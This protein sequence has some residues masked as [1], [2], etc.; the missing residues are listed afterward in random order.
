MWT[1]IPIHIF[2]IWPLRRY[3]CGV[4][5]AKLSLLPRF[6]PIPITT[7]SLPMN[8]NASATEMSFFSSLSFSWCHS[9]ADLKCIKTM[10]TKKNEVIIS[11]FERFS[12]F[13]LRFFLNT[14]YYKCITMYCV[15]SIYTH[16]YVRMIL[17]TKYLCGEREREKKLWNSLGY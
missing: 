1:T 3:D 11:S 12:F 10:T 17:R 15:F 6:S 9:P 5:Q 16:I 2:I 14:T 13:F 4:L 7:Y 8:V